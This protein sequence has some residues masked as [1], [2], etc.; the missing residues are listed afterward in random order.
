MSTNFL[1]RRMDLKHQYIRHFVTESSF[2]FINALTMDTSYPVKLAGKVLKIFTAGVSYPYYNKPGIGMSGDDWILFNSENEEIIRIPASNIYDFA[3][4]TIDNNIGEDKAYPYSEYVFSQGDYVMAIIDFDDE[5][6]NANPSIHLCSQTNF[7]NFI[8]SN[9]NDG[10]I[11]LFDITGDEDVESME[12]PIDTEVFGE[13]QIFESNN[14]GKEPSKRKYSIVR[15]SNDN[16]LYHTPTT[17]TVGEATIYNAVPV[18]NVNTINVN[19]LNTSIQNYII[20]TTN[21]Q[22]NPKGYDTVDWFTTYYTMEGQVSDEFISEFTLSNDELTHSALFGEG[23]INRLYNSL[24]SDKRD[25]YCYVIA[26]DSPNNPKTIEGLEQTLVAYPIKKDTNRFAVLST[27]GNSSITCGGKNVS[28]YSNDMSNYDSAYWTSDNL[29]GF[30]VY[31]HAVANGPKNTN[32]DICIDGDGKAANKTMQYLYESFYLNSSDR[33][34]HYRITSKNTDDCITQVNT[35]TNL[36]YAKRFIEFF[37]NNDINYINT[38]K[39]NCNILPNN[40][41]GRSGIKAYNDTE[42]SYDDSHS[43]ICVVT[44][45]PSNFES[46][47]FDTGFESKTDNIHDIT[48]TT[49]DDRIPIYNMYDEDNRIL[50][51]ELLNLHLNSSDSFTVNSTVNSKTTCQTNGQTIE[52]KCRASKRINDN[53]H[54]NS[55]LAEYKNEGDDEHPSYPHGHYHL[56][57]PV[58]KLK[59]LTINTP[60][61]DNIPPSYNNA[62]IATQTFIIDRQIEFAS[63]YISAGGD[64]KYYITIDGANH[65]LYRINPNSNTF[66]FEEVTTSNFKDIDY[67]KGNFEYYYYLNSSD[68]KVY[69]IKYHFN[70]NDQDNINTVKDYDYITKPVFLFEMNTISTNNVPNDLCAFFVNAYVNMTIV[71]DQEVTEH[72]LQEA[73]DEFNGYVNNSNFGGIIKYVVDRYKIHPYIPSGDDRFI[74]YTARYN[75]SSVITKGSYQLVDYDY[76]IYHPS[77]RYSNQVIKLRDVVGNERAIPENR[78]V[79]HVS[80]TKINGS[81]VYDSIS[82]YNNFIK[83]IKTTDKFNKYVMKYVNGCGIRKEYY[84]NSSLY[85]FYMYICN[86]DVGKAFNSPESFI[87]NTT[88]NL[89]LFSKEDILKIKA[90]DTINNKFLDENNTEISI[91]SSLFFKRDV[92][93]KNMFGYNQ[94]AILK[95]DDTDATDTYNSSDEI[96]VNVEQT[97]N[98][99]VYSISISDGNPYSVS[100][101]PF[102]G[103]LGEISVDF[104]EWN[105]LLLALNNNNKVDV[106]S[107]S[108]LNIKHELNEWINDMG[109]NVNSNVTIAE[110]NETTTIASGT[111]PYHPEHA[112]NAVF[113]DKHGLY[114]FYEGCG[115]NDYPDN[116]NKYRN[117][118]NRGVLVFESDDFQTIEHRTGKTGEQPSEY[119]YE[120][121]RGEIYPKRM[122]I[123]P[124]GILC[125][126]EYFDTEQDETSQG[127][128]NTIAG[129]IKRIEALENVIQY[130]QIQE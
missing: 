95:S 124:N 16:V 89:A 108:L 121:I 51:Y 42:S 68:N 22:N 56:L 28:I 67:L 34:Y 117:L 26:V 2:E 36:K 40:R 15:N 113:D 105:T 4:R 112:T 30:G 86:R 33:D 87:N 45:Y 126:K 130:I 44:M 127:Y 114:E 18:A 80:N 37:G 128:N 24:D 6:G 92:N 85:D 111:T 20:P 17:E 82:Y 31:H 43:L 94:I 61:Y 79:P 64:N 125:T 71:N 62:E 110:N 8:T 93:A 55:I 54:L 10:N 107:N 88:D 46:T 84:E 48:T 91:A 57:T 53:T 23:Y 66:E 13:A 25:E 119:T 104:I 90:I 76:R 1:N 73:V 11:K 19:K 99:T 39:A 27:I 97:G 65:K 100:L 41:N 32:L 50:A 72:T 118:N 75:S 63:D 78:I 98:K 103:S 60:Y 3:G 106:L 102:N 12:N 96:K 101:I 123:N 81:L 74:N 47:L 115:Y 14:E 29:N 122:Y 83:S 35:D 120:L 69:R 70:L 5:N 77:A 116:Y 58:C 7:E 59:L 9:A 49:F 129:L 109:Q 21:V 38:M 52:Y